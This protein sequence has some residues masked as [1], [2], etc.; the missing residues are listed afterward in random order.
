MSPGHCE[1]K[2]KV[3]QS[4]PGW[5]ALH[6]GTYASCDAWCFPYRRLL[7]LSSKEICE[8]GKLLSVNQIIV[9]WIKSSSVESN[10]RR[11]NQII[12]GWIKSSSVESNHHRLNQTIYSQAFS[13]SDEISTP[14]QQYTVQIELN[15]QS[16]KFIQ[17][18]KKN[19]KPVTDI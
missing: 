6:L 7:Y 2:W 14:I 4:Y 15:L 9:G 5:F 18:E 19:L 12:V 1:K 13:H 8:C 3:K 16:S 17:L 10:H 11:L